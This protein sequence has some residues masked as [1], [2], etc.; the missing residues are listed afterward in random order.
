M[1]LRL[2]AVKLRLIV[3]VSL[4]TLLSLPM[5]A[6]QPGSGTLLAGSTA[7]VQWAGTGL[8]GASPEAET[9]CVEGVNCD[10]FLLTFGGTTADW[11]GR[12]VRVSL[13]WLLP[14]TDYDLYIHKDSVTGPVVATSA[15]GT[16]TA[17]SADINVA[18]SGV[19][20]YAVRVVYFVALGDQYTG[21]A[22]VVTAAAEVPPPVS[23]APTP[24]YAN[25]AAPAPLGQGAG[26]PTLGNNWATGNTMFISGLETLRVS[27]DDAAGTASWIE[28]SGLTTS[29]TTFDPILF[30]DSGTNRTFVSQLLPAKISLM[31]FSDDDGETWTPSMGAGINS[32]V[33]HQTVGGGPFKPGVLLRGPLTA[34]PNA[35]YYA[36]Q[37]IGLAEIALSRDGGLT[38]DVAVPMWNLTQCNGLHGHIKVAPD[39]TVYVPN[40]NC[41][42]Q[43]AVAVSEDN[44]LTWQI[45]PVPGSTAGS[46]DPSVGIST[47]GTIYLGFVNSD[48]TARVAVSHNRGATWS[49]PAN[50]G[51]SHNVKNGVF[52]AVTAGDPDRAAFFFLGTS[53][54]GAAGIGTDMAFG[55]TW[56]GYIATTYDGGASWVTVNATPNDP[57]QRGV[58]CTQGTTCPSGTRN[59]LDFNDLEI[60]A[61]G[62]PV[63]AFADGCVSADCRAGVDRS[64]P[65]GTPD[66][67]IDS[68]DN[69]GDDV[70]TIIRQSAGRTLFAAYD[71]PAAPS[72]LYAAPTKTKVTLGWADNSSNESSFIVERSLSATSGFAQIGTTN[73]NGSSFVDSSVTRKKTYFYRV[74]AVNAH[75]AST[76]SSVVSAY[77]K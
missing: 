38:F 39:G 64:G 49:A 35:V 47:D 37:D 53:T 59:L 73:A 44:G 63:A 76:F 33:D 32:G 72:A 26:E 57:V 52:A 56:Y 9:T 19:G 18:A 36:S 4:I 46:T 8:G 41:G 61:K 15:Q 50:V 7:V 17:E 70:A 23:S 67:K 11:N 42:G 27:F 54:P 24:A 29:I 68:Y 51:Y 60:D 62:R 21:R 55:G 13:S 10:T 75:G 31:A 5:S 3:I 16:T 74:K 66:G 25:F 20:T 2:A 40:K 22:Q 6:S 48:G 69:D 45:R 43:Q 65:A 77:V 30:T 58:V 28:R 1:S 12:N 34:Y 71:E 14:V